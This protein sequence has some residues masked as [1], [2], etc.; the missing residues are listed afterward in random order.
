MLMWGTIK[1]LW[2]WPEKKDVET[3]WKNKCI[4]IL[5][6]W[7]ISEKTKDRDTEKVK[8]WE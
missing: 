6:K 2:H 3:K 7:Q 5:G 4:K 8:Q 1:V